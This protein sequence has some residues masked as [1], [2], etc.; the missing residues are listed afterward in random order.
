MSLLF[1]TGPGFIGNDF[2]SAGKNR[3]VITLSKYSLLLIY[4]YTG[5]TLKV[6]NQLQNQLLYGSANQYEVIS[7]QHNYVKALLLTR[8]K[9]ER[10]ISYFV[11]L[12]LCE[13]HHHTA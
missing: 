12:V 2:V 9:I 1:H 13:I 6:E 10:A 4:L 5:K 8:L 7:L 11:S 3:D